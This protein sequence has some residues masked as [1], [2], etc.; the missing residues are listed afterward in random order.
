VERRNPMKL[1]RSRRPSALTSDP[2]ER[3]IEAHKSEFYDPMS[4]DRGPND[5]RSVNFFRCC[6]H[7]PWHHRLSTIESEVQRLG[8]KAGDIVRVTDQWGN[9]HEDSWVCTAKDT[10]DTCFADGRLGPRGSEIV[11]IELVKPAA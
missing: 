4:D 8:I 6:H 3:W 2:T 1:F 7:Q 10:G 5:L 9:V 11:Y